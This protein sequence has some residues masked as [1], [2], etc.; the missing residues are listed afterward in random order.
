MDEN[1][2]IDL[3]KARIERAKELLEDAELLL[4]RGSYASANNR[5]YYALEKACNGL[6]A[7]AQIPSKSHRGVIAQFNQYF[8]S[9]NQTPFDAE[10]YKVVA[11]AETIRSK[12]DYDDFYIA[13]KEETKL[14]ISNARLVITKA[15]TYLKE[16]E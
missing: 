11:R 2:Y 8:V 7:S 6:L 16:K 12:S 15:E 13:S 14:L 5:A 1:N 4:E 9:N 3:A 10:D